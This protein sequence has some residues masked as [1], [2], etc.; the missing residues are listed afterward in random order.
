MRTIAQAITDL[1]TKAKGSQAVPRGRKI[2]DA[3]DALA[4]AMAGTDVP[5]ANCTT[6]VHAIDTVTANYTP[7]GGVDVGA[8]VDVRI[9]ELEG[10]PTV[11]DPV[12]AGDMQYV[13]KIAVGDAIIAAGEYSSSLIR[14]IS[15]AAG[16]TLTTSWL[17]AFG[18]PTQDAAYAF[19]YTFETVEEEGYDVEYYTSVTVLPDTVTM[20]TNEN[21]EKRYTFTVPEVENGTLFAVN[22]MANWD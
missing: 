16:T 19:L 3:L 10:V 2:T 20:E 14:G 9:R 8:P 4:D 15:F 7:G 12:D 18:D 22:L 21:S 11:G 1:A 17:P 5:L 13:T 6:I